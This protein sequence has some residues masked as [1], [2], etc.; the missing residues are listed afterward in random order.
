MVNTALRTRPA[1]ILV[2]LSLLF[3]L[4]FDYARVEYDAVYIGR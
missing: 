4:H 3:N 2:L 1:R